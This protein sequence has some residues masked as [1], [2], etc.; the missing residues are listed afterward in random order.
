MNKDQTEKL[1]SVLLDEAVTCA[2]RNEHEDALDLLQKSVK[3]SF[4]DQLERILN[5]DRKLL[6]E[7][8]KRQF[9]PDDGTKIISR[10]IMSILIT[11]KKFNKK[12]KFHLEHED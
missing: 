6:D 9:D 10:C 1:A 4:R 7:I 3:L 8:V 11:D 2:K 12:F 5:G